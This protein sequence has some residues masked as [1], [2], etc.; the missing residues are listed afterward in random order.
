MK[1]FLIYFNF[2]RLFDQVP[3]LVV[4]DVVW[5]G[6]VVVEVVVEVVVVVAEVIGV[7]GVRAANNKVK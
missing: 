1:L 3:V 7:V 2:K 6:A 4:V 5:V